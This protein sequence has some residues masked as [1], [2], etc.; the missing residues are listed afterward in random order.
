MIKVRAI[1]PCFV[2]N[3]TI[4][5]GKRRPGEYREEDGVLYD[6]NAVTA[7]VVFEWHGDMPPPSYLVPA[8]LQDHEV[9]AYVRAREDEEA[10]AHE[11]RVR[12]ARRRALETAPLEE[13]KPGEL[14]LPGGATVDP[15]D[16]LPGDA[17]AA[18]AVEQAKRKVKKPKPY[19]K[20]AAAS[21]KKIR[22]QDV[23]LF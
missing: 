13:P 9:E 8:S 10:R 19:A 7:R 16:L 23:V 12:A 6:E 15:T 21:A 2:T 18:A 20:P 5:Y 1:E 4:P 11:A 3:P 14:R 17:P 22:A